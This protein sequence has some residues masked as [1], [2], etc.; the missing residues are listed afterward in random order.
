MKKSGFKQ[1][2]RKPLKRTPLRRVSLNKVKKIKRSK[3]GIWSTHTADRRFSIFI[4]LRDGHCLKCGTTEN[5][6]C[7][8]FWRRGHS[9]TRFDPKNCI[10]LC[11]GADGCHQLWED[12]KN[13]EYKEFMVQLLG[14]E[15]YDSLEHRA[16]SFKNRRD[17]VAECRA[18]LKQK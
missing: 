10:A 2:E 15:E 1:K 13:A 17:A 11:G 7:S 18:M 6:T 12:K 16:R 14:K 3:N 5:L 4:R 9:S 8:H